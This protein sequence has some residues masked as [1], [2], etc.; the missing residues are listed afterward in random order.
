L[1]LFLET[2]AR[3]RGLIVLIVVLATLASVV[4]SLV[5]PEWYEANALLLPPKDV[6]VPVAGLSQLA[7]VVSVVEGLNL[8]VMVTPSDV[9]ARILRSRSIAQSVID[10]FD[11]GSRYGAE[12]T[13]E[14]YLVLMEHSRFEV[15]EEGLLSVS[16]EDKDPE[17]AARLTNAF[18]EELDRLNRRIASQRAVQNREFVEGRI[19][20]IKAQLDSSRQE[21][22]NFQEEHRTVD[23]DEQTRLAIEQA[24]SLKVSL[25]QLEIEIRM[26]EQVLGKDNP[27]LIEK[28][29]RRDIIKEQLT[30]LE[31][32]KQDSSFFSL[33]LAAVPD[34]KG[35]YE[36]LYSRVK[37]NERLYTI[38]LEQLEQAKLQ[39]NEELPTISVLDHA[40]VPEI[41]SR[42]QRTLIV[43][44]FAGGSFLAALLLALLLEYFSR[45]RETNPEEYKRAM[46]V[47]RAFFGW[48]PGVRSIKNK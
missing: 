36:I 1:W 42:P 27:D 12:S 13:T 34:L 6:T 33:P 21:F 48:L 30:E 4:I 20:Q 17:M 38:M 43:I 31:S 44:G 37:V 45:L 32:G 22:E 40:R 3:R 29:R 39:E 8:P 2:L 47:A 5:L 19:K 46:F 14:T 23:F 18:V 11:L 10:T 16:V 28:Q 7:E 24:I 41:R 9:Y 26:N 25:A 15:T 35:Q